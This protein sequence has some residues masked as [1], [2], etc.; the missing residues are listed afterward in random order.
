MSRNGFVNFLGS[1][2][3]STTRVI[4]SNFDIYNAATYEGHST[5]FGDMTFTPGT[6]VYFTATHQWATEEDAVT[7]QNKFLGIAGTERLVSNICSLINTVLPTNGTVGQVLTIGSDGNPVWADAPSGES[8][9]SGDL[10]GFIEGTI[11]EIS[12]SNVVAVR[13][14]AFLSCSNLTSV[15]F[16]MCTSIDQ[17]A[18]AD[19]DSLVSIS[20]P[21]CL[22]VSSYAFGYCSNL[23][24]AYFPVC[25]SIG[26]G[27]FSYCS[28]LTSI[29]LPVC[30]YI[31]N[32]AF[33]MCSRLTS[34]NFPMCSK[35]AYE[36]FASC[37]NLTFVNY[38]VCTMIRDRA[39]SRCY[40]L[41]TII[42]GAPTVCQLDTSGAFTSTPYRGY[43][44]YFSGTPYIYVPASLVDSYKTANNWSYFSN[45]F[46]AIE[47]M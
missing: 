29:S 3:V 8:G 40:N 33:S 2:D 47:D 10:T 18:F 15:N 41:S 35:I 44:A 21:M 27:V 11:T 31:D 37:Y 1:D 9:G 32:G 17:R 22:N 34:V 16:P 23:T 38:P 26:S 25:S 43:S 39:F 24:S 6:E 30:T 14:Y 28:K 46:S 36:T 7:E 12:D 45:Y 13:K 19:C 5:G 20:F 42:L 4:A